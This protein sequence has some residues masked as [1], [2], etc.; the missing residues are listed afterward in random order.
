MRP[1]RCWSRPE[2]RSSAPPR[3]CAHCPRG[4]GRRSPNGL[5]AAEDLI[6]RER[7][8]DPRRRAIAIVLTDGR[9]ADRDGTVRAAAASLGRAADAVQ[10]IDTEDGPVRVGL[11]GE[12][13]A[14][15]RA[16]LHTLG[17]VA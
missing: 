15:A 12:L 7:A 9:V 17:R 6:R 16:E 14:A 4:D 3:R 11:T 1:P 2:R 8:R 13:A 5:K 10:V